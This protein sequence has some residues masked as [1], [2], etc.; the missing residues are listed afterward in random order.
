[1]CETDTGYGKVLNITVL[2]EVV[3]ILNVFDIQADKIK[4]GGSWEGMRY[5]SECVQSVSDL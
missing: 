2:V 4:R 3:I 1:M 5:K